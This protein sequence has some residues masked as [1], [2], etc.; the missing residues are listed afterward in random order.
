M[1]GDWHHL[2]ERIEVNKHGV[3]CVW[4]R[5]KNHMFLTVACR[6]GRFQIVR[7]INLMARL[8]SAGLWWTDD[9]ARN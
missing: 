7:Y 6:I 8:Q 5:E 3:A 4:V 1:M 9:L 2:I